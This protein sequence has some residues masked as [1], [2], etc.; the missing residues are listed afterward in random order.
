MFEGKN[1]ISSAGLRWDQG[2]KTH[3]SIGKPT[4][5][6]VVKSL[7]SFLQPMELGIVLQ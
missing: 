4:D 5:L 7:F 3:F 2:L 1:I 6:F